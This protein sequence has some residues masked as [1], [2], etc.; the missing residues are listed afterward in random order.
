MGV[1]CDALARLAGGESVLD[2]EVVAVLVGRR[3]EHDPLATLTRRER[4]ILGLVAEGRSNQAVAAALY[5]STN[6]VET[7]IRSIFTK[8]GLFT[9]PDD[10]RRVLAVLSWLSGGGTRPFGQPGVP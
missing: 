4:E 7:H 9:A 3:R 6:T 1:L 2:P 5:L 10:H 8:L